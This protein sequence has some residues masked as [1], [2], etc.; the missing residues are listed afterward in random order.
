MEA[1]SKYSKQFSQILV[2]LIMLTM[3]L[4]NGGRT[5]ASSNNEPILQLQNSIDEILTILQSE[6]LKASEKKDERE[7][8][9][10][11]VVNRMFDFRGM[12]R[13]SLGQNWNSLTGM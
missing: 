6:E 7:E 12:A 5:L 11:D 8:L 3:V 13:S 10:L 1:M 9:I 4:F 2:F